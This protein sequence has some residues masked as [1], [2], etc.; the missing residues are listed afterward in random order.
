VKLCTTDKTH[1][2]EILLQPFSITTSLLS[3]WLLYSMYK[4]T[5]HISLGRL[6][7]SL[8]WGHAS[9]NELGWH[10]SNH[11]TMLKMRKQR[12]KSHKGCKSIMML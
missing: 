8:H 3:L 5:Y 6:L 7:L 1:R 4:Q 11:S 2:P 9:N 10:I 12:L